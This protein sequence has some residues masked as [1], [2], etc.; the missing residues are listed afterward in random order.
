MLAPYI[1]TLAGAAQ[2][3]GVDAATGLLDFTT[4]YTFGVDMNMGP[5]LLGYAYDN[6]DGNTS[7]VLIVLRQPGGAATSRVVLH[8]V[9]TKES[10]F[11]S[12]SPGMIVP[13]TTAVI[14][15]FACITA[16]KTQDAT[17]TVWWGIDRIP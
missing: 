5:V 2:F 7:D 15:E 14:W 8:D 10:L 3:T 16:N 11:R 4:G 12:C 13:R 6:G 17:L 9:T 1:L